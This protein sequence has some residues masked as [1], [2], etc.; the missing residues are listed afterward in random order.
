MIPLKLKWNRRKNMQNGLIN[1]QNLSHLSNFNGSLKP[2]KKLHQAVRLLKKEIED[3]KI[4]WTKESVI[5]LYDQVCEEVNGTFKKFMGDAFHC[6]KSRS[7]VIQAG[8][9]C[10]V[11]IVYYKEKI[12][13]TNL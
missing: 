13:G 12:C 7:E 4:P 5:K 9:E 11:R 10:R 6:P 2:V 8:R 1:Y 3:G